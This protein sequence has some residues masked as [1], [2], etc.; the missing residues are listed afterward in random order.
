MRTDCICQ[1]HLRQWPGNARYNIDLV[2]V[3]EVRWHRRG[4]L[5]AGDFAF[6]YGKCSMYEGENRCI[7]DFGGETLGKETTWKVQA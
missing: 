6:F 4:T 5:R 1:G 3:Q 7:Q 2:G